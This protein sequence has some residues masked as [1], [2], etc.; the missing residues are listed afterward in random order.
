MNGK[1]DRNGI[2]IISF[3]GKHVYPDPAVYKMIY[4]YQRGHLIFKQHYYNFWMYLFLIPKLSDM[5]A[6][7]RF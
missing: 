2:K 4:L 5:T 3:P 1:T 7:K 6:K